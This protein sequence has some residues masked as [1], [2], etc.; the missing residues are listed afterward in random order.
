MKRLFIAISFHPNEQIINLIPRLRS[1]MSKL[2]KV[3]WV[4][5]NLFHLTLKFIGNFKEDNLPQLIGK[6]RFCTTPVSPFQF[7]LDQIKAF[8]SQYHPRVII[9]S[10]K[11]NTNLQHLH[12]LL[13]QQL[14][15]L[16]IKKD[17]GNFVP[18]LTL[19]RIHQI[20]D[21]KMF[22]DAIHRNQL[23]QPI[24]VQVDEIVLYESILTKG[25]QPQYIAL[26]KFPLIK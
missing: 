13:E 1:S 7:E 16:G 23:S 6:I 5:A 12:S 9:L 21:R 17:V 15:L 22:W 20:D 10:T 14:R 18:H 4:N 2:D 19:A 26:Q 11:E 24:P 25:Y 3:N 8:G